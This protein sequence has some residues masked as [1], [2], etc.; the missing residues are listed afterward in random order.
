M[1]LAFQGHILQIREQFS[2]KEFDGLAQLVQRVS[3]HESQFQST[4]NHKYRVA[5]IDY[6]SD[7]D[8]EYEIGLVEWSRNRKT[9]LCPWVKNGMLEQRYDFDVNRADKIF[10]L[11]LQEKQILLGPNHM[12]PSPEELKKR[13]VQM[14]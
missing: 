3:A 8:D 4:Q 11:L 6:S 9:V 5:Q 12:L 1:E 2:P 10:D 7:S 13:D 14:T